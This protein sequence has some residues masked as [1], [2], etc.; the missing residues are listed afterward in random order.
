[1]SITISNESKNSL[2]VSNESKPT[3]GTWAE[4]TQRQ[5]N[6]AEGKWAVPGIHIE[7]ESKNSITITNESK[8]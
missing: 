3:G 5:W 4:Q 6:E 8:T 2:S 7:K 1:M